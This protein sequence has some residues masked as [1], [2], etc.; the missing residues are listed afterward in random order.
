MKQT[1]T[2]IQNTSV[3]LGESLLQQDEAQSSKNSVTSDNL[4]IPTLGGFNSIIAKPIEDKNIT[5][6]ATLPLLPGPASIYD[7]IY[8][9]LKRAQGITKWRY[10]ESGKTIISLDLDLYEKVYLL[11]HGHKDLRNRYVIRIGELHIVFTMS[12]V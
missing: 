8:T 1:A 6:V 2:H 4:Q 11:V 7:A 3:E 5:K 10:G 9:A 12:S